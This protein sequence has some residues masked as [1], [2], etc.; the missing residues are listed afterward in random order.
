MSGYT[1]T[2]DATLI[3]SSTV[4]VRTNPELPLSSVISENFPNP[5]NPSTTI[6]FSLPQRSQVS[7]TVF[8][9]LGQQVAV[10]VNGE[11]EAGYH[12]VRFNGSG[13]SSGVYFYR[14][15]VRSLDSA[16]GRDS[17]SGAGSFV[18]TRTLLLLR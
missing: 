14:I 16:L 12:D 2:V 10:L 6:R 7:L 15:Q 5:F 11:Q 18:Q 3:G 13:L 17:R 9:A 8:N 4:A 1:Y